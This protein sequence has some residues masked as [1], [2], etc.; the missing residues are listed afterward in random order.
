MFNIK[1]S[2]GSSYVDLTFQLPYQYYALLT[3]SNKPN[4]TMVTNC[5][6]KFHSR[7]KSSSEL[8]NASLELLSV[9]S[10]VTLKQIHLINSFLS[11][12]PKTHVSMYLLA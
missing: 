8:K 4:P 5:A 12:L 10:I 9:I 11:K 3:K 2:F 7:S 6:S 1:L